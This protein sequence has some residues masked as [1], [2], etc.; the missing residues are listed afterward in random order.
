MWKVFKEKIITNSYKFIPL[1]KVFKCPSGKKWKRP[2]PEDVR[3]LVK[4]NQ[5]HG[6]DVSKQKVL[7]I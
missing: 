2:L 6:E 4:K 3:N 1:V 5:R 7:L